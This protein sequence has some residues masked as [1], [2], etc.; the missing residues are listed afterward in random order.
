[1]KRINQLLS[2]MLVSSVAFTAWADDGTSPFSCQAQTKTMSQSNGIV[3]PY[4]CPAGTMPWIQ[5]GGASYGN[6]VF[7]MSSSGQGPKHVPTSAC[8]VYPQYWAEY[9]PVRHICGGTGTQCA[10]DIY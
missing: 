9:A 2:V 6:Y 8:E 7:C 3:Q 5:L 4:Q 1:M 10:I